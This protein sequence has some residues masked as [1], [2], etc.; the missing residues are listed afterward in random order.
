MTSTADAI[1]PGSG[2]ET[3]TSQYEVSWTNVAQNLYNLEVEVF[4]LSPSGAAYP[5]YGYH[6]IQISTVP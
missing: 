6:K 5:H 4:R 2:Y 3:S 1:L